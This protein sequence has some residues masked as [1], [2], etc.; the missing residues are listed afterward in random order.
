MNCDAMPCAPRVVSGGRAAVT[1]ATP[2][3]R[4][5]LCVLH[6]THRS[7]GRGANDCMGVDRVSDGVVVV[8]F[9]AAV[10]VVVVVVVVVATDCSGQRSRR[11]RRRDWHHRRWRARGR[12]RWRVAV[13]G[14]RRRP[15]AV[16]GGRVRG[17]GR[18]RRRRR[19]RRAHRR[20][21]RHGRNRG[22]CAGA[23][24]W[25]DRSGLRRAL[26]HVDLHGW[27]HGVAGDDVHRLS[28]TRVAGR[29][30]RRCRPHRC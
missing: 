10:V 29:R 30:L 19:R 1:P 15:A 2:L 20:W 25:R 18:C 11:A 3:A 26:R 24:W 8:V 21:Q 27:L 16:A 4:D 17:V 12:R 28:N 7:R 22:G 5:W 13:S 23:G 14:R 6:A 9:G